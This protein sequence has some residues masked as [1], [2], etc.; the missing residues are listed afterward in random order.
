[1]AYRA[2]ILP[3]LLR[4]LEEGALG[5]KSPAVPGREPPRSWGELSPRPHALRP[6]LAR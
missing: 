4:T 6:P 3:K 5:G 1:M 2:G